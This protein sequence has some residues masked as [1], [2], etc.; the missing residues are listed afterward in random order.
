MLSKKRFVAKRCQEDR[1]NV[2]MM[3]TALLEGREVVNLGQGFPDFAAPEFLLEA[4]SRKAKDPSAHSLA[5]SRG[6][7]FLIQAIS[8]LYSPLM[9][10]EIRGDEVVSYIG[11][12]GVL[13]LALRSMLTAGDE[14]ILLE[15]AFE[16]YSPLIELCGATPVF[17]P[18]EPPQRTEGPTSTEDWRLD[19]AKLES[20]VS[21]KTTLLLLN[22]PNNPLGKSLSK[23]EVEMV[24][25]I[26]KKHNLLVLSDEVYE[27]MT[28]EG[29]E[30]V[31]IAAVEGMWERTVSVLSAGKMFSV[32]GWKVGWAIG[33]A[34]LASR[35]EGVLQ[36]TSYS[37][38]TPLQ[39]AV[40][41]GVQREVGFL[42]T[43]NGYLCELRRDLEKKRDALFSVLVE[44]GLSPVKPSGTYF[45]LLRIPKLAAIVA[46]A[47][48][49]NE[50]Y[51]VTF[52]KWIIKEVGLAV[53]P[54]TPFCGKQN[55][56]IG[57]TLVRLCF[58]KRDC[59][60]DAA[61][62]KIKLLKQKLDSL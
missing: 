53:I 23:E 15:P 5:P 21:A 30:H 38:C 44:T 39:L 61:V 28:Y 37:G 22:N 13:Y 4:L 35:L 6:H 11:A 40:A 3:F 60:L 36:A 41:E 42:G 47:D 29:R 27:W 58:A 24:A 54:V 19:E 14:V 51:D 59:T 57:D 50:A 52:V 16:S 33:P 7:P 56:V 62:E 20:A 17:V 46:T 18:F 9:G 1:K 32:T 48:T 55:S 10:H 34:H 12:Y 25:G 31:R 43:P 45:M 8:Q 49:P 26:C 2:W